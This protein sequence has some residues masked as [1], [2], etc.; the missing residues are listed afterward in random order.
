MLI[1]FSD[2][3]KGG[4]AAVEARNRFCGLNLEWSKIFF[5]KP[6]TR[7]FSLPSFSASHRAEIVPLP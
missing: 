7:I 5:R 4:F 3:S 6:L 2:P 1:G